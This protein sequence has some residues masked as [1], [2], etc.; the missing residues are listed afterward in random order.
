MQCT[1]RMQ[2]CNWSRRI[3]RT[4]CTRSQKGNRWGVSDDQRHII[5][6]N[7]ER[8]IGPIH[9]EYVDA[10]RKLDI[11]PGQRQ[12]AAGVEV[13]TFKYCT[14]RRYHITKW[15]PFR[16][17]MLL[18]KM[19]C[20]RRRL[21]H[22]HQTRLPVH[23]WHW[24]IWGGQ[25]TIVFLVCEKNWM[26][27]QG[28]SG[29]NRWEWMHF[30]LGRNWINSYKDAFVHSPARGQ[31]IPAKPNVSRAPSTNGTRLERINR[32]HQ[33]DKRRNRT[34]QFGNM[35]AHISMIAPTKSRSCK[36]KKQLFACAWN[37]IAMQFAITKLY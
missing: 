9:A 12:G 28:G 4:W 32:R 27:K 19:Q 14:L 13:A 15:E 5:G 3:R 17:L 20:S 22:A 2:N 16:T 29:N 10:M 18:P 21:A 24:T 36:K 33:T 8:S 35:C 23:A 37:A 34:K 1:T 25:W 6:P 30:Q 26:Q 11:Q 31:H 7:R